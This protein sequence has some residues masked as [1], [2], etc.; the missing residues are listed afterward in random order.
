MNR[1]FLKIQN[2]R[3]IGVTKDLEEYQTLYLNNTL[4][5]D[6]MGE[7][8]I[9]IG[10]NNVG[11]SNILDAVKIITPTENIKS[12][13]LKKDIPDFMDYEDA[14]PKIK[15]IYAD[16]NESQE[17]EYF[18]DENLNVNYNSNL[19][20]EYKTIKTKKTV[21][22]EE[23]DIEAVKAEF[24]NK[25]NLYESQRNTFSQRNYSYE[26]SIKN[27][28]NKYYNMVIHNKSLDE[29]VAIYEELKKLYSNFVSE[30]NN[31]YSPKIEEKEFYDLRKIASKDTVIEAEETI[32][33]PKDIIKEK[34]DI[35]FIP[36]IIYYKEEEVKD[37]DLVTTP[38][39]IKNSKFFNALFKAIGKN[40]STVETAYEKA[41]KAPDIKINIK[42]Q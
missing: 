14:K 32:E 9:L 16:E 35:N 13:N 39:N 38:E 22:S 29:L 33:I 24:K 40:I 37:S 19:Q 8:I 36:N 11:K 6:E 7:L 28:S 15:L 3:N 5:K 2:F 23:F 10:E 25:F 31:Y 41:Q 12:I 27:I 26:S 42:T 17:I 34:Y 1:R 18:L 21:K 20:K 30:Y 4:N